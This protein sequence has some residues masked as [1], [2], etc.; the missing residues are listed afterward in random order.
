MILGDNTNQ[1]TS[2]SL[3]QQNLMLE[4]YDHPIMVGSSQTSGAII[5]PLLD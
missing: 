1:S 4:I 3:N 2:R 5:F